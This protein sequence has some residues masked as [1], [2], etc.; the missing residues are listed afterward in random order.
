MVSFCT[1]TKELVS[2]KDDD[3]VDMKKEISLFKQLFYRVYRVSCVDLSR[4]FLKKRLMEK[5][6]LG[7]WIPVKVKIE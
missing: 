2:K 6:A 4:G 7:H 1:E 3:L 5:L